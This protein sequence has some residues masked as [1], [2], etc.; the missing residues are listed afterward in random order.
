MKDNVINLDE[1]RQF[2]KMEKDYQA[3]LTYVNK[4]LKIP[5]DVPSLARCFYFILRYLEG[6]V[7]CMFL[8]SILPNIPQ[9]QT[10]ELKK[11]VIQYLEGILE[12]LKKC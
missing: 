1:Y 7:N 2:N 12:D 4:M 8:L 6:T 11:M 10:F 3:F 9:T 5:K